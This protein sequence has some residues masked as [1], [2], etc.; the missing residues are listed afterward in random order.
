MVAAALVFRAATGGPASSPPSS[1]NPPPPM[2]PSATVGSDTVDD[3]VGDGTASAETGSP[4]TT[5]AR[6]AVG[7]VEVPLDPSGARGVQSEDGARQSA[8]DYVSTVRQRLVYLADDVG[9]EVLTAW[10]APGVSGTSIDSLLQQAAML[11]SGLAADGGDV[12]WVVSPLASRVDAYSGERARVSVWL[13]SVIG[14][15]ADPAVSAE[16]TQPMVRFQTDTVELVWSSDRWT[17]WATTSVDGPTPM[18]APSMVIASP[19]VFI[20]RMDGF[21]LIRRHS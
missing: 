13:S 15:G 3:T 1:T 2:S 6:G 16:S 7:D 10:A 21:S 19:E 20:T 17:V 9:R 4:P 14:A 11:R 18:T 8:V 5:V 12:W